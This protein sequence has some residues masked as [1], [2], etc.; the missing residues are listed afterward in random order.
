MLRFSGL[1]TAAACAGWAVAGA[2]G[3]SLAIALGACSSVADAS[4]VGPVADDAGSSFDAHHGDATAG[5][6]DASSGACSPASV[7]SFEPFWIKPDPLH[8]NA[9]SAAQLDAF[10]SACGGAKKYTSTCAAFATAQTNDACALCLFGPR[11]APVDA[12]PDAGGDAGAS[13]A[14]FLVTEQ[15]QLVADRPGCL[16]DVLRDA[17]AS[18][19]PAALL[20]EL[21]CE[22]AACAVNCPVSVNDGDQAFAACRQAAAG[23]A[24]KVYTDKASACVQTVLAD[25]GADSALAHACLEG[26][27]KDIATLFCGPAPD[28]GL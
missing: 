28:A 8:A 22:I 26:S 21:Q 17:T 19:C 4:A 2:F 27:D 1:L 24:C 20:A 5:G 18:G 7:T 15:G 23:D 12:G 14:A 3:A 13:A 10:E 9:C 16:A 6:D 25:G 11:T